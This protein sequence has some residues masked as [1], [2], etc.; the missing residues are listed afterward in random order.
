MDRMA[1]YPDWYV[2]SSRGKDEVP[3]GHSLSAFA[4][5]FDFLYEHFDEARR[6]TYI[7][8]IC[9]TA[10][11]LHKIVVKKSAGWTKQFIH[12]H[13]PTNNLAML[14]GAIVCEQHDAVSQD[15]KCAPL[16]VYVFTLVSCFFSVQLLDQQIPPMQRLSAD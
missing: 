9:S 15:G 4:T 3:V 12:N 10:M 6:A 5:A 1:S 11:L 13:A 16:E 14:L 2:A 7:R 8:K